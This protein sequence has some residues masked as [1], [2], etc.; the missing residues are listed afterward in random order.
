MQRGATCCTTY[1]EAATTGLSPAMVTPS[2]IV[3]A[4]A[5]A[6]AHTA[7]IKSRQYRAPPAIGISCC[8][9]HAG[10][11]ACVVVS[12]WRVG[13]RMGAWHVLPR[14]GTAAAGPAL[15]GI[16]PGTVSDGVFSYLRALAAED[17]PRC[18]HRRSRPC[19]VGTTMRT[20]HAAATRS[21][22]SAVEHSHGVT[23]SG[24]SQ[25]VLYVLTWVTQSAHMG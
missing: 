6:V 8:S 11:T 20:L 14:Q 4:A 21:S 9:V 13:A 23:L 5:T 3:V 7:S 24:R 19:L 17:W 16:P 25:A 18:R 15:R 2:Q 10:T 12:V 1:I 22:G